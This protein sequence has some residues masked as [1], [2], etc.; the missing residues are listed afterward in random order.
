M[1]KLLAAVLA[2]VMVVANLTGCWFGE[3][4]DPDAIAIGGIGPLTGEASAYGLAVKNGAQLA[5]D[6][7]NANGG[8]NGMKL[9]L[10]FEDDENNEEKAVNA[11]NALKDKGVQILM[12]T[13]TSSPCVTVAAETFAD[14]MFQITPSGSSVDCLI[15]DNAYRVCFSDPQQ[16]VKSAEYVAENELAKKVAVIYNSSD[17]YST[18]IYDRFMSEVKKYDIEIVAAEAF[19]N[20]TIDFKVQVQKVKESGAELVFMPIYYQK[21]AQILKAID[22]CGLE[23][24]VLGC[25]GFD[26]VVEQLG[27]YVSVADGATFLTPYSPDATDAESVKFTKAYRERYGETPTQFAADAYDAIYIIKQA[28]EYGNVTDPNISYSELCEIMKAAMVE[29]DFVGVTGTST[30]SADGEPTKDLKVMY[31]ENGAYKDR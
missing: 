18:G 23:I 30:W 3:K 12:G 11:Y 29:I 10:F 14:N 16:A 1:K 6:E 5:V 4:K 25:D 8:V 15:H 27:E 26:G 20:D 21:A 13:V 17:V 28:L 31:I 22:E 7:I 19:T 9:Q 24:Q 2:A